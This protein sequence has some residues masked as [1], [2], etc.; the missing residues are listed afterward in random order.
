M[1]PLIGITSRS[2]RDADSHPTL[3]LQNTYIHAISQAGGVPFALPSIL[4]E[5]QLND[6]Y[7]KLGGIVFS[8]GGDLDPATFGGSLHSSVSSVDSVRDVTEIFLARTAMNDGKP[9]L[10]ICRG[11]QLINVALG[12]TLYT[13]LPDQLKNGLDHNP[14]SSR[15][16]LVH[17]VNVD[18]TSSAAELFG[19]TLLNVNSLHHQGIKDLAPDMHAIGHAPDGLI[20]MVE[21]KGHPFAW[22]VQ[23][24][25]EWLLDQ[26]PMRRFFARF[27]QVCGG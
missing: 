13:H 5:D 12:G 11:A 2:S 16:A 20:E 22:A 14:G 19:C 23:W 1:K 26:E 10:G 17:P 18:E 4:S 8:G 3:S 25:P 27:I 21:I 6:L 15:T 9:M 24:H 7:P